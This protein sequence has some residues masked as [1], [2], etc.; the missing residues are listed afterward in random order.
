[1]ES[2]RGCVNIENLIAQKNLFISGLHFP[3]KINLITWRIQKALPIKL[4]M[5]MNIYMDLA[6]YLNMLF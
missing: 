5:E 4:S 1:M 6:H 2:S 3:A